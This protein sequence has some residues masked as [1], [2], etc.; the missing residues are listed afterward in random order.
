MNRLQQTVA[1]LAALLTGNAWA[2]GTLEIGNAWI[3]AAPPGVPML[4]G[5]AELHNGGDVALR[6]ASVE[7]DA[8]GSVSL[9][10]TAIVDGVSRMRELPGLPIEAGGAVRLEPGAKHLMLMEPLRPVDARVP[11]RLTFVLEDGRRVD[12]DFVITERAPAAA[13]DDHGGHEHHTH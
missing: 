11:V 10:E 12:A 1:M 3:R 13:G 8:F 4:A 6:V 5:Y 2:A 9:H 7:S